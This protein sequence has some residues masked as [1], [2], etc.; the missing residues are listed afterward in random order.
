MGNPLPAG[1]ALGPDRKFCTEC[2]QR[3]LRKA[4]ICP[5]CGCRQLPPPRAGILGSRG[6]AEGGSGSGSSDTI[7]LMLLLVLNMLWNGLG[8]IA[9]GDHRG[10]KYAL[11]N[12]LLTLP[13]LLL[14][15]TLGPIG[16]VPGIAF[17]AYCAYQGY[18]YLEE[19]KRQ[20]TSP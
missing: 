9:V 20:L 7:R 13:A 5:Y 3:I 17:Y 16:F 6:S 10:W 1:P 11:F 19:E 12:L 15:A 14:L 18:S 8:N 2:G 4:E